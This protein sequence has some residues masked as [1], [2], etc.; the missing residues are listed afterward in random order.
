LVVG[1]QQLTAQI[2]PKGL[3]HISIAAETRQS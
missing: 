1:K 2:I 3:P